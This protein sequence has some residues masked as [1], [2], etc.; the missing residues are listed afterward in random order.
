M[1]NKWKN[2]I[3]N[4]LLIS[5]G[6]SLLWHFS[7]IVRYGSHYIQEPNAVILWA[8]I[9]WVSLVVCWGIYSLSSKAGL[10]S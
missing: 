7:N 8:E 1:K 2:I 4:T 6:M 10:K 9:A 3:S 5:F